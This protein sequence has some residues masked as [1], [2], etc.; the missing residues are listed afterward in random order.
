M[1]E[2]KKSLLNTCVV[3]GARFK[4][5]AHRNQRCCSPECRI[6]Y[7][8]NPRYNS[9]TNFSKKLKKRNELIVR[10]ALLPVSTL[11]SVADVY[12][13]TRER[14]RQIVKGSGIDY[15]GVK[16]RLRSSSKYFYCYWCGKE[17][18]PNINSYAHFCSK[19]C[20]Q[21][22]YNY[23]WK[24]LRTCRFCGRKFFPNRNWDCSG[25]RGTGEYCSLSCWVKSKRFKR[26]VAYG[27]K[28]R[29]IWS[30]EFIK[31]LNKLLEG[32]DDKQ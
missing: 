4:P 8:K 7:Q 11:A 31:K 28:K 5:Y 3:C 9:P 21:H 13:I 30:A 27:D 12:G 16:G 26:E 18:P 15:K 23:D 1:N 22:Y 6:A 14:V 2:N 20:R 19:R 25:S 29:E 24:S 10:D 32:G 17:I